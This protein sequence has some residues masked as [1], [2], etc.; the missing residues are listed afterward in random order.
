MHPWL[1]SAILLSAISSGAASCGGDSP[2]GPSPVCNITISPPSAD[3]G[4]GSGSGTASVNAPAGCSWTATAGASWITITGG[5]SGSGAGS[6]AYALSANTASELRTGALTIGGQTHTVRQQG[7]TAESCSYTLSHDRQDFGP[8]S[9]SGSFT[10]ST[11]AEC[12]WSATSDSPWVV[13]TGGGQRKGSGKVDY[14]VGANPEVPGRDAMIS[15]A[16]RMFEVRQAGD[17]TRCEYTLTPVTFDVCM[18]NGIVQATLTTQASCPWTASTS[19]SWISLPGGGSGSGPALISMA[20][21][22][23]YDAPRDGVVM[24]RWPTATAGQNIRLAQAGCTYGV[25]TPSLNFGSAGGAG[26]FDVLQQSIPTECGGATQDRCVWTAQTSVSWIV[27][28]S[29]M[30]RTGDNPVTFTVAPNDAT[31][32]RTGQITV[33]DKTVTI[34]QAGR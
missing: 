14:T 16:D 12:G 10:V 18:P 24:V 23:N 8:A 1:K 7:R 30:P 33:R 13:I 25:S 11:A 29:S 9:D 4:S 21:P 27:V 34:T 5:A 17:V 15:V 28:T 20:F 19:A 3:F 26:T 22:A 32:P 6:V 31:Q 2:S